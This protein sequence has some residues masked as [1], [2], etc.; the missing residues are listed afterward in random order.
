MKMFGLKMKKKM[1]NNPLKNPGK[2]I[3]QLKIFKVVQIFSVEINLRANMIPPVGGRIMFPYPSNFYFLFH[4]SFLSRPCCM[5][6]E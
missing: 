6:D 2:C 4:R 3:L 1:V 5:M